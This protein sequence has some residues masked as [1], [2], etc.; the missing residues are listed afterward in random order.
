MTSSEPFPEPPHTV[1]FDCWSTLIHEAGT[2]HGHSK[3]VNLISEAAR[4]P[5][6][7]AREALAEAWRYHQIRWHARVAFT[8]RDMT[9]HALEL[10]GAELPEDRYEELV[11]K[12]EDEALKSE[13]RALPGAKQTLERL[14]ALGVRRA[15]V[16]DTGFSP[17]RV[18]RQLLDRVGLL[19]LLEVTVFSDEILVPKPHPK[20]FETALSGLG[21]SASGSVHVGD[22]RRSDVAGARAHGM[23][24]IRLAAHHDD[25]DEGSG[26]AAG[27]IDCSVAGCSPVC[28]RPEADRVA[29][30]YADVDR[31]LGV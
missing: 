22:L 27:V 28:E 11:L 29:R 31:I 10:L 13:I 19:S 1:T 26:K 20:A 18:V 17:G 9:R 16:C 21:V 23:R 4:S 2:S 8:A 6:G 14:K 12:L 5:E 15:L 24:T 3:R 30:S 25:A 7:R